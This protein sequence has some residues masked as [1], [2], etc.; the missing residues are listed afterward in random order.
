MRGEGASERR[1][2]L[3]RIGGHAR[4]IARKTMGGAGAT[5]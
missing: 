3:G 2:G 5:E 1:G 4:E